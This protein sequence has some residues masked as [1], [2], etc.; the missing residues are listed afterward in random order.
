MTSTWTT[1]SGRLDDQVRALDGAL[2]WSHIWIRNTL[3]KAEESCCVQRLK[4]E[5][6][7]D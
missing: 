3:C 6:W 1:A 2:D 5:V 4:R 7:N